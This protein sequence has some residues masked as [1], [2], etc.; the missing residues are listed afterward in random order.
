MSA[1][2]R[3]P[4]TAG[5]RRY[6]GF[7]LKSV[8][9]GYRDVFQRTI[10]GLFRESVLGPGRREVTAK[11]FELMK[12]A[13]QSCF[14]H[15]LKEFLGAMNPATRWLVD[16]PGIFVD[17]VDLG[18][19]LASSKL[20][21]GIRYFECLGQGGFGRTPRQVRDL[22]THLRRLREIDEDLAV[23]FLKGYR[24]LCDRMTPPQIELYVRVG[25]DIFARNRKNGLAF[26]AGTLKTS[27]TYIT[28]ITRECPLRDVQP[29]LASMLKALTGREFEIGDLGQLDSD[30]L[31]ERGS[32][33]VCLYGGLYLPARI[34]HFDRADLNRCWYLLICAAAAG[35]HAR[36]SFPRI[37]G[38]P[39]YRTCRDVVG[40]APLR[41]NL[42][43]ILE[44]V[45][46][47]RWIDRHWPGLRRLV[48]FGLRI[49]FQQHPPTGAAERLF[50]DL[51]TPGAP[52]RPLLRS[53]AER[54]DRCVNL[55]DTAASLDGEWVGQVLAAYPG[56]DRDGL[57]AVSFLPD[58]LLP[59]QVSRPPA[60]GVVADLKRAAERAAPPG[61]GADAARPALSAAD[62]AD[63]DSVEPEPNA[64]EA[65]QEQE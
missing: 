32:M 27:E 9:W 19:Q 31:L 2:D 11:F 36:G 62:G 48:A 61:D 3:P 10:E 55:F 18:Q 8:C 6:G 51:L 58:F 7:A 23:A 41:L 38:H 4:S 57:R 47:L 52:G 34:R 46:V 50:H 21:Y 30:D 22:L 56:L 45:R 60:D 64:A 33:V 49:E 53:L 15:V 54:A 59:G 65:A 37:H 25:L 26:L 13:D 1:R 20:Y 63:A 12:Q 24:V 29:V 17:V 42:F 14:D 40:D 44:Y 35:L 5:E 43:Q 39:D 16:L 28:S